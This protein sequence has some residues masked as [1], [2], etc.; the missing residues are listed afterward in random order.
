MNA[1][2]NGNPV[3]G[4]NLVGRTGPAHLHDGKESYDT[5]TLNILSQVTKEREKEIITK[6]LEVTPV[7]LQAF[8]KD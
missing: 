6:G 2:L 8:G 5:F 3:H 4:G 7:R 1:D